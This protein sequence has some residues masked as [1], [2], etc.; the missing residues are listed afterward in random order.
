MSA[1]A[2]QLVCGKYELM[3]TYPYSIDCERKEVQMGS[4]EKGLMKLPVSRDDC[5]VRNVLM[6]VPVT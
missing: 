6:S 5:H 3:L 1:F 4:D 2:I